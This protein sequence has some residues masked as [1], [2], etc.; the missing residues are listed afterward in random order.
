MPSPR[1][2]RLVETLAKSGITD[3]KVTERQYSE[4][5]WGQGVRFGVSRSIII[6]TPTGLIE[7]GDEWWSK[8]RDVWIGWMVVREDNYGIVKKYWQPTKKRSEVADRVLTALEE[9]GA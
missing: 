1:W 3:I 7:I 6:R 8:N 5:R 4:D 2:D 9:A